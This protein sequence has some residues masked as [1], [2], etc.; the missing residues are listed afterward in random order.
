M[1]ANVKEEENEK[2]RQTKPSTMTKKDG[3]PENLPSCVETLTIWT[4]CEE[5]VPRTIESSTRM[6]LR[7]V[8]SVLT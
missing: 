5:V 4:I 1:I 6:T 7:P 8:N 2:R 3:K